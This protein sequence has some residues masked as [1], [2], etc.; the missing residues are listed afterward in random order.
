M[1]LRFSYKHQPLCSAPRKK[2]LNWIFKSLP[3]NLIV[4]DK[5]G[6]FD[7]NQ[8]ITIMGK[9]SIKFKYE[10]RQSQYN[11]QVCMIL[12]TI[13][14]CQY[15][16]N[17]SKLFPSSSS[18]HFQCIIFLLRNA[19]NTCKLELHCIYCII[20]VVSYKTYNLIM[21]C[22]ANFQMIIIYN[23]W[24]KSELNIKAKKLDFNGCLRKE[25]ANI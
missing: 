8:V 24:L 18:V 14:S 11:Y 17:C 2:K 13:Q 12:S 19:C 3:F 21:H 9:W 4:D 22:I 5:A 10:Q 23:S 1:S 25:S 15:L 16:I 6:N 7:V 20:I